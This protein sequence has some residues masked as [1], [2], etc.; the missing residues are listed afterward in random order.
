MNQATF[1]GNAT[2]LYGK[3]LRPDNKFDPDYQVLAITTL[4]GGVIA[5]DDEVTPTPNASEVTDH[6]D[7]QAPTGAIVG[8]VLGGILGALFVVA[9]GYYLRQR[10]RRGQLEHL[11]ILEPF[12]EMSTPWSP[13]PVRTPPLPLRSRKYDSKAEP[14]PSNGVALITGSTSVTPPSVPQS[15]RI[16]GATTEELVTIL[17]QRLRNERWNGDEQPPEYSRST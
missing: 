11:P 1:D 2:N 16:E 9:G 7:S 3:T 13:A 4:L 17:N 12:T 5:A 8:G 15:N 10:H 14:P 6:T